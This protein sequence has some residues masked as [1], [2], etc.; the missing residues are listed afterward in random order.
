MTCVINAIQ[1]QQEKSDIGLLK[2]QYPLIGLHFTLTGGG[3]CRTRGQPTRRTHQENPPGEPIRRTH[4]E[5]P[6]GEPT[7]RTHRENPPGEP[8]GRTHQDNPPGEPIRR[9]HQENPPG[10]RAPH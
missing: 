3:R 9:T 4:R 2:E 1:R 8:T 10:E 7:R 5:N 6:P